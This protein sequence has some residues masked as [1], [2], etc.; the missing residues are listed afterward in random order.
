MK[1]YLWLKR[2]PACGEKGMTE[3]QPNGTYI[4]VCTEIECGT[5][6]PDM[7]TYK[8]AV[9]LWNGEQPNQ[10]CLN[11]ANSAH[12]KTI[13]AQ[14]S[15]VCLPDKRIRFIPG[16]P[17]LKESSPRYNNIIILWGNPTGFKE[18]FSHIGEVYVK[19]APQE[20]KHD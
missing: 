18:A 3:K 4:A 17:S 20:K 1:N 15:A 19:P 16:H 8:E 11:Y 10:E 14:S 7:P 6:T 12:L 5:C 13:K 9:D 2:C